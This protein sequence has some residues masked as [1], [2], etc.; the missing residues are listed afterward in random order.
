MGA[1]HTKGRGSRDECDAFGRH[2][3][4]GLFN[5]QTSTQYCEREIRARIKVKT[6]IPKKYA[7][8]SPIFGLKPRFLALKPLYLYPKKWLV[9]AVF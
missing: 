1:H 2:L 4:T 7:P 6:L 8:K 9:L 3:L 5:K